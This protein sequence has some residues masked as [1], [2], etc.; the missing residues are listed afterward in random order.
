MSKSHLNKLK[1]LFLCT[2]NSCRS[3]MAE[4]LAR[5]M[6]ENR[7][8]IKSAGSKP[9]QVNP[10]AIQVM[11]EV[12]I[13]ISGHHSK[14]VDDLD[15]S[16]IAKLDYVVTLCAEEVCPILISGAK[17]LHWPFPDPAKNRA[18]REEELNSFRATRDA[19]AKT[20]EGFAF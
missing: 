17:K 16:F 3:Q 14:S 10:F 2:G 1:I 19:I 11:Q 9:S 8:V 6:F 20:L 7:A 15:P 4:G 12:G 18:D 13:D 5:K